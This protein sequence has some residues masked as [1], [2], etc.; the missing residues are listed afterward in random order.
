MKKITRMK[1]LLNVLLF[2]AFTSIYA[3]T[4]A[5]GLNFDG[6]NDYVDMGDV[7]AA[8][9]GTGDFTIEFW[10]NPSSYSSVSTPI[11]SKR[12]ECNYSNFWDIL[13]STSNKIQVEFSGTTNS[14]QYMNF[15]SSISIPLNQWTHIAVVRSGN[16][17]RL[18]MDNVFRGSGT[19][20]HS[21][22]NSAPLR[23][24]K[25]ECSDFPWARHFHGSLD[26]VRLWNVAR[27][28]TEI[29][30]NKDNALLGNETG[31][32]AYYT[33]CSGNVGAN[34]AGLTTLTDKTSNSNDGTLTN[35][36]LN[37]STSNWAQGE[38]AGGCAPIAPPC[39]I[40]NTF[41][42]MQLGSAY[43]NAGAG[44]TNTY[45]WGISN[46][47]IKATP[48]GGVGPYTYQWSSSAGNTIK[49]DTKQRARLWYPT[50]SQWVKV[51]I[52]DVGAGCTMEDSVFIDWVDFTCNQPYIW[53]YEMCNN[54]TNTTECVAATWRMRQY[55]NTGNYTFGSCST[56]TP[57]TDWANSN[58]TKVL[59]LNVFPNPSNGEFTYVVMGEESTT[60]STQVIDVNGRILFAETFD[61][62][63]SMSTREISLTDLAKG[64]YFIK[65]SGN[66]NSTVE[67]ISIQ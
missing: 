60:Y 56:P 10:V 3:Q 21:L 9:F 38:I 24:G 31:L 14:S 61:S 6:T 57:K 11:I 25:D 29:A 49:N 46:G 33:F 48:A 8:D 43:V 36:S 52:T 7:A 63:E 51:A 64:I 1:L 55:V 40:T 35:F 22:N 19:F 53:Y 20:S 28:T 32:T 18:Y 42:N 5:T 65:V 27:S 2:G 59:G 45:Y 26:E 47:Y 30:A 16:T 66:D 39:P 41:S 67:R 62:N 34:N 15:S 54:T 44:A 13:I 4:P 50:G 23:L 58:E 12:D 37:G 17:V